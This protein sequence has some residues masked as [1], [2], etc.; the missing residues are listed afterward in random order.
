MFGG[1][2]KLVKSTRT[3]YIDHRIQAMINKFGLYPR[4][5]KD[6]IAREKNSKVKATVKGKVNKLL[7]AQI[8]LRSA[9]LKNVLKPNKIFSL[10]TQNK[11]P[12]I[13]K[14][15]E[16]VERIKKDYTK[17]LKKFVQNQD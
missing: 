5:L 11:D 7:N 16:S 13:V 12:R 1:G 4:H 3:H 6:F 14:T 8:I 17:L 9:F 2:V 10:V 15:A